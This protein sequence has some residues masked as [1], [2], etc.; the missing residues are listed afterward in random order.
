ME[1]FKS[2]KGYKGLYQVSNLG[3]VKSL[4]HG[5]ERILKGTLGSHGYLSVHLYK[6]KIKKTFTV[7]QLVAVLF[8][9]HIIDGHEVV[10]N[11]KD[12]NKYNNNSDNLE[13]I[14]NRKNTNKKHLK[15]SSEFIGVYWYKKKEKWRSS[16]RIKGKSKHLGYFTD[17][18]KASE[19]Y[20]SALIKNKQN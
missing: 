5:N 2:I 17:E 1:V 16:I 19:A 15:S 4:K 9:N 10:V 12:F 13:L 14:S 18:K 7:H 6:N 3:N 20:Q 11:H 8:L